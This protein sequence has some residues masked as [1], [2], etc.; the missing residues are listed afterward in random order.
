METAQRGERKSSAPVARRYLALSKVFRF[1]LTPPV[2]RWVRTKFRPEDD[3]RH[4]ERL[5][6]LPFVT[7]RSIEIGCGYRKTSSDLIGVDLVPGGTKGVAGN[8]K[9]RLSVAD[10]AADGGRLPIG[11][12]VID[13]IIA[14]HNLEH[15]VDT[16]ATLEEWYRVLRAGGVAAIVVPDEET[17]PG[18]TVELDPTHFHSFTRDSLA[19]LLSVVGFQVEL[20]QTAIP[21]WSFLIVGRKPTSPSTTGA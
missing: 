13:S 16:L 7:G 12:G 4:P 5:I 19:R 20:S 15:Y 10:I 21:R 2:A 17:Y 14:R 8:A 6:V 3:E 9:G 1:L 18:R 11:S